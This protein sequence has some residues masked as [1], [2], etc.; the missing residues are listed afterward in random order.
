MFHT[1]QGRRGLTEGDPLAAFLKRTE[2]SFGLEWRL[3]NMLVWSMQIHMQIWAK[4]RVNFFAELSGSEA[5]VHMLPGVAVPLLPSLERPSYLSLNECLFSNGFDVLATHASG[6][7]EVLGS[8]S[9]VEM[10]TDTL[11]HKWKSSLIHEKLNPP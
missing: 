3:K 2:V 10:C 9:F 8:F 7:T 5:V 1:F 4:V 11:V 6:P